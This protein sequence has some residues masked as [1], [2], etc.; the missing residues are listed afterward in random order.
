MKKKR[1]LPL[2]GPSRVEENMWAAIFEAHHEKL[3]VTR[4]S[5][6]PCNQLFSKIE[7][8]QERRIFNVF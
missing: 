8:N 3:I 2:N 6:L 7:Y 5:M 1:N 4:H